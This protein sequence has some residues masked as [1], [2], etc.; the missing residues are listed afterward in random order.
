MTRRLCKLVLLAFVLAVSAATHAAAAEQYVALGD[1]YSS[2][3]GT[4]S[5]YDS[6]CQ[7]SN[8][9]Y[10]KIIGAERPNTSVNL[11]ACS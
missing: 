7:R 1:S 11:V 10:A 2:G 5:Y 4:R 6:S 8:Y 3:T 9:S